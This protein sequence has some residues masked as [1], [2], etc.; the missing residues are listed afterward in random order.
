MVQWGRWWIRKQ[1]NLGT[2]LEFAMT[3]VDSRCMVY[4]RSRPARVLHT[5]GT[6]C[7]SEGSFWCR[8]PCLCLASVAQSASQGGPEDACIT[9][10]AGVLRMAQPDVSGVNQQLYMFK[11]ALQVLYAVPCMS[12]PTTKRAPRRSCCGCC[13][14]STSCRPG[15]MSELL[16]PPIPTILLKTI[17]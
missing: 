9:Y 14:T 3:D 17:P 12:F 11:I 8:L 15:P 6:L 2:I 4:H 7:G 16:R 1:P 10:M 13:T 5:L